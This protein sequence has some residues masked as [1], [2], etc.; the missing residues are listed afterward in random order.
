MDNKIKLRYSLAA[1]RTKRE[2]LA[3]LQWREYT[4]RGNTQRCQELFA[5]I[6]KIDEEIEAETRRLQ[7]GE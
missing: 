6:E 3:R 4:T 2:E 1:L 5:Q 7:N